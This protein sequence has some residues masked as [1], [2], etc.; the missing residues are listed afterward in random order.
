[1]P[2]SSWIWN[3]SSKGNN[4]WLK[5]KK[6]K[7]PP[8]PDGNEREIISA[9]QLSL[10]ESSHILGYVN[11]KQLDVSMLDLRGFQ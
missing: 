11:E 1:M 7:K 9:I 3:W 8:K 10:Q 4:L 6:N 2:N 5:F